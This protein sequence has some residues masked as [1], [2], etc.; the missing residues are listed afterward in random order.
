MEI[1]KAKIVEEGQV[2]SE[3]ILKVDSF[4]NH[5]IDPVLM[6]K[7]GKEFSKRFE[8]EKITKVL[9][10]EASGIAAALM[11]GLV[12][13]VPVV[14]AKKKKPS[15]IEGTIYCGRI[16]SFTR[17]ETVDIVVASKYLTNE[18]R[19]LIIDDF[20]AT[21]EA[22]KGMIEIVRQAGCY[23]VGVGICIEK[24]FQEGGKQVREMG[25]RVETLVRISA[26][27]DGSIEFM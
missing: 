7:I 18:D 27:R 15:T 6:Y 5:Q 9:T 10:V 24:S 12:L 14:F 19:V 20:L 22:A 2:L 21:G 26:L 8:N 23:L 25:V 13:G 4:L 16:H 3:S 17:N 11:T 1:L